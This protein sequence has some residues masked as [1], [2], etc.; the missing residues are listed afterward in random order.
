MRH[1][2]ATILGLLTALVA[3]DA[4]AQIA[5]PA[6]PGS[7]PTRRESSPTVKPGHDGKPESTPG[8]NE[9][10]EPIKPGH[11]GKPES[12]PGRNEPGAPIMPGHD[13]KPTSRP[14]R[15][16]PGDTPIEAP[17]PPALAPAKDVRREPGRPIEAPRPPLFSR[18]GRN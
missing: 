14:S 10:G 11:D 1:T 7:V 4:M 2:A 13:G 3:T 8:R 12:T 9:P 18:P 5:P 15:R 6:I 16:L 17:R